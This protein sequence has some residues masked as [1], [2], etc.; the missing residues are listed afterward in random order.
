MN[1]LDIVL[2]IIVA[3]SLASSIRKGLSREVIGLVTVILALLLG[4][5]FYGV[6]AGYLMPYVSTRQIASFAGFAIV[7]VAVLLAGSLAGA[8]A[9]RLLQLTGLSWFDHLLGAAFGAVRGLLI[10]I[11]L[12][13]AIMAFSPAGHPPASVVRSRLAPYVVEAARV[14]AA[15]APYELKD[16]FRKS[17]AQV[18]KA[19]EDALRKGIRGMPN[20]EK[21]HNHEREI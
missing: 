4:T 20:A 17:Y 7:F 2:L 12:V 13:M 1:W 8:L 21:A 10:S 15:M 3:G 9:G 5:W 14:C 6:V 16:G 18:H 19:W 11:A